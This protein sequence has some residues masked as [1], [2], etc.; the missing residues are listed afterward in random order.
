M[1]LTLFFTFGVFVSS[2]LS[3]SFSLSFHCDAGGVLLMHSPPKHPI[4]PHTNVLRH[5]QKNT[6]LRRTQKNTPLRHTHTCKKH[7]SPV[8]KRLSRKVYCTLTCRMGRKDKWGRN[9]HACGGGRAAAV[10][11]ACGIMGRMKMKEVERRSGKEVEG[12]G[13]QLQ[14]RVCGASVGFDCRCPFIRCFH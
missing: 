11:L 4:T 2:A 8:S 14:L 3:L 5:T 7:T 1:L 12:R 9:A 13:L 10:A 6:P